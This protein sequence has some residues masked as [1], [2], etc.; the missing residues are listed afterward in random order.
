MVAR[1]L[2]FCLALLSWTAQAQA[3]VSDPAP[4]PQYGPYF[5]GQLLVARPAMGDPRF[6]ETVIYLAD[7]D[8]QGA[9]GLVINRPMG[10]GPLKEFMQ[11]LKMEPAQ[12]VSGDVAL[13]AG[14]PVEV[15]AGFV[16]HTGDYAT[17]GTG[18]RRGDFAVTASLRVLRDIAAGKGPRRYRVLLGYSGWGPGQLENELRRG[19]WDIAPADADIL[20]DD[21][22]GS[23]WQRA[24]AAAGLP[25]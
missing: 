16:L 3:P 1:V 5:S 22:N 2:A 21:S 12:D 25:M 8:S 17:D 19:D 24:R 20:F 18:M 14:G 11:G 9:F 6:S 23:K 4:R 13:F 10:V 7:H 15:G